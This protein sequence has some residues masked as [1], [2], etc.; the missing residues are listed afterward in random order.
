MPSA[1]C[2]RAHPRSRDVHP[3]HALAS[4]SLPLLSLSPWVL[5]DPTCLSFSVSPPTHTHNDPFE[6]GG[7]QELPCGCCWQAPS[8]EAA[9]NHTPACFTLGLQLPRFT[10]KSYFSK[11]PV[12]KEELC[13]SDWLRTLGLRAR[14]SLPASSSPALGCGSSRWLP[15]EPGDWCHLSLWSA[16]S[17]V[18]AP[19]R[20]ELLGAYCWGGETSWEQQPGPNKW[21]FS[22]EEDNENE[23]CCGEVSDLTAGHSRGWAK[24]GDPG[25]STP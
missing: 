8:L 19:S 2:E 25:L 9:S 21:C 15:A 18:P 4:D 23:T 16:G 1:P 14:C 6:R 5:K 24:C 20:A 13:V 17:F 22:L 12:F 7:S 11:E 3:R 10:E